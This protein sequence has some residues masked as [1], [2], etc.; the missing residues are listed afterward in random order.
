MD[1]VVTS[2]LVLPGDGT[3]DE[4]AGGYSD[5]EARGG[6]LVAE[7]APA[8][9]ERPVAA[10]TPAPAAKAAA[11]PAGNDRKK[12]SYREQQELAGLPARIE[13][14]ETRQAELEAMTAAPDFYQGDAAAV[15][16]TLAEFTELQATLEAA[17]ERWAELEERA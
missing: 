10:G 7:R 13:A 5:W 12:L 14:L 3:I 17:V 8:D 16:A 1:N 9:A 6:G 11:R 15:Q 4:Q 2:L